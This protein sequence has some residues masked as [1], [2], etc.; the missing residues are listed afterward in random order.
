[1]ARK[2]E[3][4]EASFKKILRKVKENK[5]RYDVLKD[6]KIEARNELLSAWLRV[7]D[8]T[9][10]NTDHPDIRQLVANTNT[11]LTSKVDKFDKVA[12]K[13]S[14]KSSVR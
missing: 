5:D 8:D 6:V 3:L 14:K 4:E 9:V 10:M 13:K 12:A 11:L 2:R 7:I 1:M